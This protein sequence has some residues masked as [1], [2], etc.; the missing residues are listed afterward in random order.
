[1]KGSDDVTDM[2]IS[3]L[4]DEYRRLAS[5]GRFMFGPAWDEAVLAT[6]ARRGLGRDS[7]APAD[8]VD[9]ARA[10]V[11]ECE[12][13]HGGG[14]YYWGAVVNGRP[15]HSGDCYQCRG[16]GTQDADDMRRNHYYI[17]YSIGRAAG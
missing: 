15:T 4:R 8:W 6:L 14:V 3:D 9:A 11:L 5:D 2:T 12:R 7:A 13:C 16:N 1:L 10:T 17:L